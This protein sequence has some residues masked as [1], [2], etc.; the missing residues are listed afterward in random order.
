M[1]NSQPDL[2]TPFPVFPL[3]GL[4]LFPH[5]HLPLHIF[6]E[7]Y[8]NL[9]NDVFKRPNDDHWFGI[10]SQVES[11]VEGAIGDPPV[12][13]TVGIGR[14]KEFTRMPDG[15]FMIVLRGVGRAK[16][17]SEADKLNGYRNFNAMWMPDA[18]PP[19]DLDVADS[20]GVEIKALAVA[21]LRDQADK[22]RS[23][24]LQDI[25]LGHL[26]DM[27]CGYLPLEP[28]FKLRMIDTPVVVTRAAAVIS[29]LEKMIS[30]PRGKPLAM[31]DPPSAN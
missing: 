16:L 11:M 2:S 1:N 13:S 26:C 22:F 5:T 21:L 25:T 17:T 10:G 6:E 28:D 30:I 7:R 31:D 27:I 8:R 19:L 18:E 4:T 24:L 23:I 9:I 20:M 14:I 15:R 29:E 3:P 12:F